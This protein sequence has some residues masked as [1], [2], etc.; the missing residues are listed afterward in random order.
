MEIEE[1]NLM[2]GRVILDN[3]PPSP[4]EQ[5]EEEKEESVSQA[6]PPPFLE[7][8]IH[9]IQHTPEKTK[10]LGELKNLCVKIPLHKVI[11]DFP[12]YNKLIKD[13]CYK[14]V[15]R[16]NKCAPTINFIGQLF[17]LMLGQVVF[18]KYLDHGSPVVDVHIDGIIVP[19]TLP[20]IGAVINVMNKETI[21]KINLQGTLR[22][23]TTVLQLADKST[24][25]PER[26]FEDLMVSINCT[27]T[28]LNS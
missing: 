15:R 19:H 2:F 18:L 24:V 7:R 5:H 9:L 8:L 27:N 28:L 17:D 12:I 22:K 20:D 26:V 13:K 16:R 25:S 14:H 10:I 23:T 11:K 6:S 3:K 21:L 4:L 1:I